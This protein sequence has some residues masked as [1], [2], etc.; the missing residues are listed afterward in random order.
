MPECKDRCAIRKYKFDPDPLDAN[1]KMTFY[2]PLSEE[3][4]PLI[5]EKALEALN[6]VLEKYKTFNINGEPHIW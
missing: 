6:N 3:S 5:R 2:P 4:N 1:I